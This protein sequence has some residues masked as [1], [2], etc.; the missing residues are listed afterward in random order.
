[1]KNEK[2]P[3]WVYLCAISFCLIVGLVSFANK[4]AVPFSVPFLVVALRYLIS[5]LCN[6][7]GQKLGLIQCNLKGKEHLG[8]LFASGIVYAGSYIFQVL[9]LMYVDSI[10]C[11]IMLATVPI[12]SNILAWFILKEKITL[13]QFGFLLLSACALI[14]MLAKGSSGASGEADIR[15]IILLILTAV[16]EALNGILVRYLKNWYSPLEISFASCFSG[17]ALA[18]SI[19]I[20][21]AV[22]G[23]TPLSL[24]RTALTSSDFLIPVLFLA[25]LGTFVAGILKGEI[26]HHM[27]TVKA[28]IWYNLTTPVSV[29]A[30]V[31]LLNEPFHFYQF[32]CTALIIVG[33]AGIQLSKSSE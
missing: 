30:G 17:A 8:L 5:V 31:L 33:V 29:L 6:L 12:W 25:F 18:F 23:I 32:I 19:V 10:Y 27:S 4:R 21:L 14:F 24:V 13:K 1:M 26:L 7:T 20:V 15:G 22:L 2:T 16:C 3:F 11:G 9:G 28:M